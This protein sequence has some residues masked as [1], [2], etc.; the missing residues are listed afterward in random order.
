[1]GV[2]AQRVPVTRKRPDRHSL[3]C[4]LGETGAIVGPTMVVVGLLDDLP[5]Q[6]GYHHAA[7]N[8]QHNDEADD[9]SHLLRSCS[10]CATLAERSEREVLV[11]Q[12]RSG[13]ADVSKSA[14][15]ALAHRRGTADVE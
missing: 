6:S 14:Q 12:A 15:D 9:K 7:G 5:P 13:N 10:H 1:M 8:K 3:C 11:V 2:C 4:R